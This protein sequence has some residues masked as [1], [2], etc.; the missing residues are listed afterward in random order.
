[1]AIG[2]FVH[3]FLGNVE[4]S[5]GV[6]DGE[7]V[8]C[9]PVVCDAPARATLSRVPASYGR[10]ASDEGEA[11]E[12]AE[13]GKSLG[14][15][16]V[17]TVGAGND[18]QG[19][20]FAVVRVVVGDLRRRRCSSEESEGGKGSEELHDGWVRVGVTVQVNQLIEG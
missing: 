20:R 7:D 16:A 13:G 10:G 12:R 17:C 9:R 18:V 6:V 2:E 8:D 19:G 1:M 15:E 11:R 5:I 3:G 4:A 14:F